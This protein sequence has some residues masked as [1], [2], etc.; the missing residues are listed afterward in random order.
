M[1]C[2]AQGRPIKVIKQKKRK[3][4][5][6]NTVKNVTLTVPSVAFYVPKWHLLIYKTVLNEIFE[7]KK[8]KRKKGW[9]WGWGRNTV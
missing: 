3:K 9:G 6:S 2:I 8:R 5:K 4:G 7:Q 1:L